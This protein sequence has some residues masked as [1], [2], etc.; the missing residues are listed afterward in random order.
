MRAGVPAPLEQRIEAALSDVQ[1]PV[2][3]WRLLAQADH[4]GADNLTRTQLRDLPPGE[5]RS[6]ANV[7]HALARSA[8]AVG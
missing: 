7:V 2:A 4:N 3:R 6:L 1:F 8:A 5:Y